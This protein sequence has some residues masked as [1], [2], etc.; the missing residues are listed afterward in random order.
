MH[1]PSARSTVISLGRVG[2]PTDTGR[3]LNRLFENRQVADYDWNVVIDRGTALA[4]LQDA[5]AIV[6]DCRDYL[7]RKT[8][9]SMGQRPQN[10]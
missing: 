7:C 4:D 10:V 3:R 2:C 1:R 8:G 9:L 6:Q 5:R